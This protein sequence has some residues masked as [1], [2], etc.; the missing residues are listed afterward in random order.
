MG[1]K[2]LW[3]LGADH[4]WHQLT[5]MGDDGVLR[6]RSAHFNGVTA[7]ST[8][9]YNHPYEPRRP[10]FMHEFAAS[11]VRAFKAYHTLQSYACSMGASV[12]NASLSFL[13]ISSDL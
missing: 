2:D 7:E 8:I 10:V 1:M 3:V 11:L 9:L 6:R 12:K 13:L 5:G 4:S